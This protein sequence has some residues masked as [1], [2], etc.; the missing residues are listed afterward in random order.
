MWDGVKAGFEGA[1]QLLSFQRQHVYFPIAGGSPFVAAGHNLLLLGFLIAAVPGVVGV[2]RRLPLAYGAYV[3]AALA[4]PLS[5]PVTPQPLMSLPRFLVVLFPLSMWLAAWLAAHPRA[6][7]PALVALG[8]ADGVLRGPVRHL[9][10]GGL[11]VTSG[12]RQ[13]ARRRASSLARRTRPSPPRRPRGIAQT[14][15]PPWTAL[16]A[17]VGGLVLAALGAL[18]VDIPAAL[19]LGVQHHRLRTCPEA[20]RSPTRWCRTS[21]F[22]LAAV[23]FAQLGGRAVSAWQ[24]GLRPAR[25]AGGGSG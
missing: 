25:R 6:Q 7:R 23:F 11:G 16:A 13:P 24:F 12:R 3:L 20:S 15:W 14:A 17:L 21:R 2:L 9:A 10:L 4:L 8:P 18:I 19:A 1:R 22:V 5:Y